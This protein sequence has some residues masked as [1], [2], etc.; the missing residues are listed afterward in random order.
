MDELLYVPEKIDTRVQIIDGSIK[1]T[2][3]IPETR[4]IIQK[5]SDYINYREEALWLTEIFEQ[6]VTQL[7][8]VEDDLPII[9]K[10]CRIKIYIELLNECNHQ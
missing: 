10:L 1:V 7:S 9:R 8:I 6:T 3:T 4:L 2:M 5:N